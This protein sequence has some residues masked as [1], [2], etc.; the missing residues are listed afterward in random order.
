M[1]ENGRCGRSAHGIACGACLGSVVSPCYDSVHCVLPYQVELFLVGRYGDFLFVDTFPDAYARFVLLAVVWCG[2][3]SFL[4]SE[5]ITASVLCHHKVIFCHM[6]GQF[7]DDLCY[8]R[9]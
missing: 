3:D 6:A 4:D 1:E 8:G 9:E 7:R 5:E 2:V